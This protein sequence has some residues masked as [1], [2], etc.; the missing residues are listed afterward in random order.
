MRNIFKFSFNLNGIWSNV[1][2]SS[3]VLCAIYCRFHSI[4]I[5]YDRI[6]ISFGTKRIPLSSKTK[7]KT[8]IN[9]GCLSS[10][11]TRRG[12]LTVFPLTHP[13]VF[14]FKGI[15]YHIKKLFISHL[16]IMISLF[17]LRWA[18]RSVKCLAYFLRSKKLAKLIT[19]VPGRLF[20]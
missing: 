7:W 17:L 2:I 19:D 15:I 3:R 14:Y 16:S 10:S 5:E 18:M 1:F 13:Y 20:Q 11:G 4:S 12:F 9:D 8:V 6:Y